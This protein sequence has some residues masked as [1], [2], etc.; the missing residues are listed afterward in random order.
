MTSL[1]SRQI[2]DQPWLLWI[3]NGTSQR[4]RDNWVIVQ[5]MSLWRWTG[6]M[7]E[8]VNESLNKAYSGGH[9]SDRTL[10]YLLV[11]GGARVGWF[12]LLPKLHK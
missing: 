5:Y 1:S 7:I 11:N 2:R 10:K 8:K 6:F 12:Y 3:R 9:I 4:L